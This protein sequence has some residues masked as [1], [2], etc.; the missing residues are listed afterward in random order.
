MEISTRLADYSSDKDAKDIVFL[1]DAYAQDIMGGSTPLALHVKD[2]LVPSLSKIAHAF[3]LL[4]YVDNMPVGL[5]NCFEA[6]STFTCKPLINIHDL[7]VLQEYRGLG[8]SQI[9][10]K[11]VENIAREKGCSKVTLEVLE[12]NTVA[13]QAYTKAGF[14]GYELDAQMGK[15]LF[16][17]KVL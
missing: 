12:G 6:F 14:E 7:A 9:L 16:W 4:A 17:Q 1:L 10:L 8:I 5:I 3:S 13:Q 11:H 2:N 15:A